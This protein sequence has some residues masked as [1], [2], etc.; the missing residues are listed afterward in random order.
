MLLDERAGKFRTTVTT[1]QRLLTVGSRSISRRRVT[2]VDTRHTQN[3]AGRKAERTRHS[4]S[5]E[6]TTAAVAAG[7]RASLPY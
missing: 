6:V 2:L 4:E 7:G 1:C 3:I 5:R